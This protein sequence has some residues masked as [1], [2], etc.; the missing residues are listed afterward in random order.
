ML[1][2]GVRL[3]KTPV[4]IGHQVRCAPVQLGGDRGH[5]CRHEA[6]K[7]DSAQGVRHVFGDDAHVGRLRVRQT[8][9]E[10]NDREAGENPGPGANRIVRNV[11]PEDRQQA[12]ALVASAEN[13][14]RDVTPAAGLGARI[15]EG[16]PLQSQVDGEGDDR[17]SP[18]R[19][20]GERA[21]KIR[22][23]RRRI[24]G[25]R[26]GRSPHRGQLVQHDMH[27]AGGRNGVPGHRNHNRHLQ[28]ELEQVGPEHAPEAAE[29]HIDSGERYEEED[30]NPQRVDFGDPQTDG[31]DAGHGLGDP[32]E[33]QT[34]H[35]Q[36]E[37]KGAKTAQ[38]SR[39]LARVAHLRELYVG[40]QA[41]AP[42]QAGEK[43][44]RHHARGQKAPPQPV[45][46]DPEFVD[47]TGDEQGGIGGEGGGHHGGA[48]QPPGDGASG[49]KVIVDA[50]ARAAA[51]IEA[52]DQGDGQIADDGRPVE[53]GEI[54]GA[55]E[56]TTR[57]PTAK[58][59]SLA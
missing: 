38:E 33:D 24:A 10:N 31:H 49:D 16:P 43:K 47:Q 46:G 34:V 22:E 26:T 12:L 5:E 2:A 50:F 3:H 28:H 42:P 30:A 53:E 15:P 59:R 39:G 4:K 51:K 35:Q 36:A 44:H 7:D 32:A 11:E 58:P 1:F 17:Q 6:G 52:Q 13:T 23:E 41:R 45:A 20:K 56:D 29:R 37:V 19:L 57:R 14:L 55:R 48:R 40:E 25:T 21:R 18:Q 8:G 54:H 9:I 27:A